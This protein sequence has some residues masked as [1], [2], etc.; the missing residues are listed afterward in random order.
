MF[1]L[2]QSIADEEERLFLH[3]LYKKYADKMYYVAYDILHNASDA[4]DIVHETF[5]ALCDNLGKVDRGFSQKTWNYI[6]TIVKN[7]SFNLYNRKKRQPLLEDA[8]E[9][10]EV[11]GDDLEEKVLKKE[12]QDLITALLQEMREPYR[13]VLILQFYHGMNAEEIGALLGKSPDNV[14]HIV[15][16]A[17]K[18]L[19]E[20][21]VKGGVFVERGNVKQADKAEL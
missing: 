3:A 15:I 20:A 16:R 11:F 10:Q 5:V 6:I 8:W 17:K 18:K 2:I 9:T 21:L 14:R 1:Q 19:K 4:E 7:R 12:Q 13:D